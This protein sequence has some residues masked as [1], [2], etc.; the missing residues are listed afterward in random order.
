MILTAPINEN[1]PINCSTNGVNVTTEL[2]KKN[3]NSWISLPSPSIKDLK[4]IKDGDIFTIANFVM[5]NSG[6]YKCRATDS[7]STTIES[8]PFNILPNYEKLPAM[9]V[10][11]AVLTY[12]SEG[13][14]I[15]ITCKSARETEL[16]WY[17]VDGQT[18]TKIPDNKIV[19]LLDSLYKRVVL[20]INNAQLSDSGKYKCVLKSSN[21]QN[22]MLTALEILSK[23]VR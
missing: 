9:S 4:V 13:E 10:D 5:T 23:C 7:G 14:S 20:M 16:T 2:L 12:K 11:P 18:V 22:D 3:Q 19:I 15:N 17:K 21:K 1:F 6:L 8:P